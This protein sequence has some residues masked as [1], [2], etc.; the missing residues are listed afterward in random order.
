MFKHAQVK[1][2]I[3]CHMQSVWVKHSNGNMA[4]ARTEQP[5]K[6]YILIYK[7]MNHT[8]N[9]ISVTFPH[10]DKIVLYLPVSEH[11]DSSLQNMK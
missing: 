2:I 4:W 5:Q 3:I 1:G 11:C 6:C 8:K 7:S 10:A 9:S